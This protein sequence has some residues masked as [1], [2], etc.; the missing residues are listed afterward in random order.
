[1]QLIATTAYGLE[2]VVSRE[3]KALGYDDQATQDGRITFDADAVAVARCN[4]WLRSANRVLVKLAEFPANDFDQ[5]YDGMQTIDWT[6]WVP[7]DGKFPVTVG[8]VKSTLHHTPSC[9]SIAKKSVVEAMRQQHGVTELPETGIEVPISISIVRNVATVA[10]DTSGSGLHRRGYRTQAGAAPMRETLAAALVQLSV[11]NPERTFV[12]PFCGS[13][14]IAIEAALIG[15]NIAPGLRRTFVAEDWP[16]FPR[17]LW[18]DAI[19]EAEELMIH[20]PIR[21]PLIATDIAPGVLRLARENAK[22]AGVE[23]DIHFQQMP[24]SDFTSS[25]KYGVIITNPPYGERLGDE[26]GSQSTLRQLGYVLQNL[27]TWSCFLICPERKIDREIGREANRRRKL[28]NGTIECTY[29]Q[30]LGP[31]PPR[32]EPSPT[33]TEESSPES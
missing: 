19:A 28:Y 17:D 21:P 1:M 10:L 8:S 16:M 27:E 3:L 4:L 12:D 9:Q 22:R 32:R 11:W 7:G 29:H 6:P 23:E 20:E 25:K 30:F 5:L 18:D 24:V 13:G 26:A 15:R 14:T 31:R 2:A 33:T